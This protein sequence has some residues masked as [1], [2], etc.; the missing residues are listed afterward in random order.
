MLVRA[1]VLADPKVLV[2]VLRYT[3]A[4]GLGIV[5]V[6]LLV[7]GRMAPAFFLGS[8]AWGLATGGRIW[9]AGLP[10]ISGGRRRPNQASGASSSVRAAWVEMQLDHDTGEMNGSVLKGSHAGSSLD[11][12]GRDELATLYQEAAGED[13]ESGRLIEAYLDRRFG[14]EWRSGERQH[15]GAQ[16]HAAMS[17]DEALKILG[18][19]DGASEDEIRSTHRRL[20]MQI[21]P[22]RGGSDYLAAKINQA[23]DVLLGS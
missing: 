1:F 12:L 7:T 6:L 21:H 15:G 4:A 11:Q 8:M 16:E 18:L 2:Q 14:P 13:P 19:K 3:A 20:M 10:H 17:R 23:R 22:D 9:P 5:S